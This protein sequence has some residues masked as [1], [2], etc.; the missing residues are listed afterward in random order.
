MHDARKQHLYIYMYIVYTNR[1]LPTS[2]RRHT[3]TACLCRPT[4]W[5][6]QRNARHRVYTV[7]C[8]SLRLS[9]PTFV[10]VARSAKRMHTKNDCAIEV[11]TARRLVFFCGLK[12]TVGYKIASPFGEWIVG[13]VWFLRDFF[14]SISIAEAALIFECYL[15]IQTETMI[16][17]VLPYRTYQRKHSTWASFSDAQNVH[18]TQ[19]TLRYITLFGVNMERF[20]PVW[21]AYICALLL[22]TTQATHIPYHFV[23]VLNVAV[24]MA[25]NWLPSYFLVLVVFSVW[26]AF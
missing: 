11:Q 21:F 26:V 5:S 2:Q 3:H 16:Y 9:W 22:Y 7:Y 23:M 24:C 10:R 20:V 25:I 18:E 15:A 4:L 17:N 1:H 12:T 6:W 19:S 13:F 8:C 14:L